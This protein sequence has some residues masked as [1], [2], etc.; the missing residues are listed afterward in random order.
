VLL[1]EFAGWEMSKYLNLFG[2]TETRKKDAVSQKKGLRP[3]GPIRKCPLTGGAEAL[4]GT[5]DG[6]TNI[7]S[8]AREVKNT[9]A[10]EAGRAKKK[11]AHPVNFVSTLFEIANI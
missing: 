3:P 7:A 1:R 8:T 4:T 10:Y 5:P 2:K 9:E 6:T 11:R